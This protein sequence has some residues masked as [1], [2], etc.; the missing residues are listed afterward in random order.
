MRLFLDRN[1]FGTRA[2]ALQR[3]EEPAFGAIIIIIIV[4]TTSLGSHDN[5]SGVPHELRVKTTFRD[6]LKEITETSDE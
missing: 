6:A 1:P 5:S 2:D 4:M 3:E